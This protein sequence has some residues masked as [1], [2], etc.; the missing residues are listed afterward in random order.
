MVDVICDAVPM[1]NFLMWIIAL[2]TFAP[3]IL[4]ADVM[5]DTM[6]KLRSLR[7]EWI[8]VVNLGNIALTTRPGI[9]AMV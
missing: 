2:S 5:V 9:S 1:A 8:V 7:M 6:F 4:N 3:K